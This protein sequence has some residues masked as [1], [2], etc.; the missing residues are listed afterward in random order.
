MTNYTT[1]SELICIFSSLETIVG[2]QVCVQWLI[3]AKTLRYVL[4]QKVKINLHWEIFPGKKRVTNNPILLFM[5]LY[6]A[7][8]IYHIHH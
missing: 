7:G 4:V 5:H 8:I 6:G 1:C 3:A 2:Q